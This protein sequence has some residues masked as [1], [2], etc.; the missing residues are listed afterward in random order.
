MKRCFLALAA[1][2]LLLPCGEAKAADYPKMTIR[3]ASANPPGSV[4]T[5]CIDK[6]KEVIEKESEGAITVQTFYGGSLGDEQTNVKHLRNGSVQLATLACG[7]LTPFAPQAGVFILPYMFP[8]IADAQKLFNN[9][10]YM[11]KMA[12]II[13][14]KSRARPLG[15][16]LGGYR[17]ITNSVKPI[18]TM[19]DLKGLKIRVPPVQLQLDSF[20]SWGVEPHPLAWSETFNALQQGVVDGQEN[21]HSVNRDQKFWEVQKY[22]TNV[23]YMLWVGPMLVS[24][25][26]YQKLDPKTKALV[27]KAVLAGAHYEWQWSAEQEAVALRDCQKH[28]MV[29][30]DLKDEPNWKTAATSIWPRFYE[31]IGG[32]AIVD[33]AQAII[34]N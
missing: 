4:L 23:H 28:G 14:E 5:V 13:A 25:A 29:E 27:E 34:E 3:A 31:G 9:K 11:D 17:V 22:I 26:W 33:E 30:N 1:L 7:N 32:K 18:K 12:D 24:E 15:W 19:E 10:P 6:F 8:Q 2:V 20:R 16:I 21:P